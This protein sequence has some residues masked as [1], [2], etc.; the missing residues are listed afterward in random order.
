MELPYTLRLGNDGL[1]PAR[2]AMAD[3]LPACTRRIASSATVRRDEV[4][5]ITLDSS[6]R[7]WTCRSSASVSASPPAGGANG[8][9][10]GRKGSSAE[11][12]EASG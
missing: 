4:S 9:G 1:T 12:G 11:P 10:G 8:G 5:L 6:C 7:R 2:A 3:E